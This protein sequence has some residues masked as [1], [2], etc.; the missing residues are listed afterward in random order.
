[1]EDE[2]DFN[3]LLDDL[4][5]QVTKMGKN[6]VRKCL[7]L[8]ILGQTALSYLLYPPQNTFVPISAKYVLVNQ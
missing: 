6:A 4:D 7:H 2:E 1:M 8:D 3:P 5:N